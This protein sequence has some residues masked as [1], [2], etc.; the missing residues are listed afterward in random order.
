MRRFLKKILASVF[1][2][3]AADK[4]MSTPEGRK[5]VFEEIQKTPS[6]FS[7]ILKRLAKD[8]NFIAELVARKSFLRDL[9]KQGRAFDYWLDEVV[10]NPEATYRVVSHPEFVRRI[11]SQTEF[12][13]LLS[14]A[15]FF[16]PFYSSLTVED[17]KRF[18]D[19]ILSEDEDIF[20]ISL[21]RNIY[22][23][24][25]NFINKRSV[26]DF[27]LADACNVKSIDQILSLLVNDLTLGDSSKG[28][29][30]GFFERLLKSP[31]ITQA[32]RR[33]EALRKFLLSS[34][35]ETL[36]SLGSDPLSDAASVVYNE[37]SRYPGAAVWF[38]HF[39]DEKEFSR[40]SDGVAV[41][42][43][44]KSIEFY[45]EDNSDIRQQPPL[46]YSKAGDLRA[47]LKSISKENIVQTK[48]GPFAF[49]DIKGFATIVDEILLNEEYYCELGQ[50]AYVIDAGANVGLATFYLKTKF[51]TA[52]VLALEPVPHIAA[53][54]K[55]NV[56]SCKMNDVE[57]REVAV[58]ASSGT[59]E[60]IV[61]NSNSLAGSLTTRQLSKSK[62]VERIVVPTVALGELLER[63][64]DFL[65]LDIEGVEFDAIIEAGDRLR[66]VHYLFCEYHAD[67]EV[68][69][70]RLG[71]LLQHLTEKGFAYHIS[72]SSW[73]E[74]RFQS[75]PL[76]YVERGVSYGIY[77]VNSNW[78]RRPD[79]K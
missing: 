22:F 45:L 57:V 6:G 49:Y 36:Q 17:R 11:S 53:L 4:F 10:K 19:F 1:W 41:S 32:L 79:V 25:K 56:Q 9:F 27:V 76:T 75:R 48:S 13:T 50:D 23:L 18:I 16:L 30:E 55:H 72:K 70:N 33:D 51:P 2:R 20:D 38:S 58:S 71:T 42:K 66:N 47:Y 73:A 59:V 39:G 65:K 3:D 52:K 40:L 12:F 7:F 28:R 14:K 46:R 26:R 77:A 21:S 35:S 69:R 37:I 74:K 44:A 8:P 67:Q 64:V 34:L 78:Q 60:L 54:L 15:E 68:N 61:D 43:A 62:D 63:P 29:F 5:V 31:V 24:S